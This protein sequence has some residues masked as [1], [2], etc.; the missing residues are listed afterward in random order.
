MANLTLVKTFLYR[1]EAEAAKGLLKEEGIEAI[2][3]ADDAGGYV[4]TASLGMGN[5]KLFVDETYA[6]NAKE[7]LQVLDT[8]VEGDLWQED[9]SIANLPETKTSASEPQD[10]KESFDQVWNTWRLIA[11]LIAL[12]LILFLKVRK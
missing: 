3:S 1:H 9:S 5:V 6:A 8:N 11:F 12:A 4:P 10:Q 7:I 2:V